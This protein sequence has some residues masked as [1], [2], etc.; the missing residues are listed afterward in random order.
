[1]SR[2]KGTEFRLFVLY[3]GPVVLQDILPHDNLMYFNTLS[4]AA[5]ILSHP[6]D[7]YANNQYARDLL[8]HFVETFKVLYG[9]YNM[10]YNVH[11]L[12]HIH[13]D[14]NKFGPL[15]NFSAWPFENF[16]HGLKN[17]VRKAEKPLCQLYNRLTE[18]GLIFPNENVPKQSAIPIVCRKT[19]TL[20]PFNCTNAH[21]RIQFKQFVL[22]NREPNNCCLLKDKAIVLIEHIGYKNEVPVIIGRKY[23]DQE[24]LPVYPCQSVNLDV[25]VTSRLSDLQIWNL[26]DIENKTLKLP[27][28]ERFLHPELK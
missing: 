19:G 20:L 11:N 2:W 8:V 7:C 12:I 25:Y 23:T 16:M 18:K 28:K 3:I 22:T 5:R 1:M 9:E 26:T 13:D 6:V 15:D 10:I 17:M 14:V 24:A 21:E 27:F 4:C